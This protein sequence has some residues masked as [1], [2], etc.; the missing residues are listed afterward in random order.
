MAA[1]ERTPSYSKLVAA[2]V[3]RPNA[4]LAKR[5]APPTFVADGEETEEPKS[6]TF[7]VVDERATK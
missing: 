5:T 2:L 7:L 6:G 1:A 3:I 4:E